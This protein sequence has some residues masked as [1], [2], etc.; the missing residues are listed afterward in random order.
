MSRT[1]SS[2]L[3]V[4]ALLAAGAASA[5]TRNPFV[6]PSAQEAEPVATTTAAPGAAQPT[7]KPVRPN[8]TS[9]RAPAARPPAA[10]GPAP[11]AEPLGLALPPALPPAL[12]A[13]ASAR[14]PVLEAGL[15]GVPAPS[16]MAPQ[17]GSAEPSAPESRV[18]LTRDEIQARRS[19]C[20]SGLLAQGSALKAPSS[21]DV[22]VVKLSAP[23]CAQG[24][25]ASED[26]V[27]ARL[28][29]N[30]TLE[31]VVEPNDEP[32]LRRTVLTL[33]TPSGS[34]SVTIQQAPASK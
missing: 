27:S 8:T 25:S 15:P 13:G 33:A 1:L 26:W 3:L 16:A 12:V 2:S 5:Q 24:V 28:T 19:R 10:R 14:G 23:G 21:G 9:A 20:P 17:E 22:L 32:S 4:L 18:F 11:A 6:R 30:G 34:E 29:G 31:L 7:V